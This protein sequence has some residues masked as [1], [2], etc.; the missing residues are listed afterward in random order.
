[1]LI[2]AYTSIIAACLLWSLNP[3][4]IK[5]A[6]E[7]IAGGHAAA[8]PPGRAPSAAAPAHTPALQWPRWRQPCP[9]PPRGRGA[10]PYPAYP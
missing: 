2:R 8:W 5:L 10:P 6:L 3:D 9:H 7:E 1:M 4:V